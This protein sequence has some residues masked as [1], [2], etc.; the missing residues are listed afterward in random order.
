MEFSGGATLIVWG[1]GRAM[2]QKGIIRSTQ[3]SFVA[4]DC[5]LAMNQYTYAALNL[6]E[7]RVE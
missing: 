7:V 5:L 1:W 2:D 3:G 6:I 4:E